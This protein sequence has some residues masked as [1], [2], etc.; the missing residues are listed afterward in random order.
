MP[1]LQDI[2]VSKNVYFP[3]L[4]REEK[5]DFEKPFEVDL[6]LNGLQIFYLTNNDETNWGLYDL[7]ASTRILTRH[8]PLGSDL[9][10]RFVHITPDTGYHCVTGSRRQLWQWLKIPPVGPE[11]MV[12]R[13]KI[14]HQR[15][16]LAEST[17]ERNYFGVGGKGY[18]EASQSFHRALRGNRALDDDL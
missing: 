5:I 4:I 8:W 3:L 15:L 16:L 18:Q 6:S 14:L 13:L 11:G 17:W 2:R 7:N 10:N 9:T 12:Q 1:L